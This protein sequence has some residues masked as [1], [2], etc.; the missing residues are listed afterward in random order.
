MQGG[1]YTIKYER[2]KKIIHFAVLASYFQ[3]YRH[4]ER[5]IVDYK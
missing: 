2:T 1:L 5:M 4:F 3:P